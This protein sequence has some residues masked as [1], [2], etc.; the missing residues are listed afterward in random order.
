MK[1]WIILW[2]VA[3]L[4]TAGGIGGYCYWYQSSHIFVD[5]VVYEKDLAQLDLRST[6]LPLEHYESV[7]QQ[8]P[9]CAIRYDLPFQGDFYADDT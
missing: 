4:L 5:D 2:L 8:L 6:G 3:A 7:R 9:E 1:K